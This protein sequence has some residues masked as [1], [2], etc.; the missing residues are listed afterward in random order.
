MEISLAAILLLER[1]R[2]LIANADFGLRHRVNKCD[3][4]RKR[5]LPFNL[6]V[7]LVLQKSLKSVQLHLHEFFE[8]LAAGALWHSPTA[9]AWTQARAKLRHSAFIEL[10]QV[11]V[12]DSVYAGPEPIK[13]WRGRRLLAIDSSTL[14]LPDEQALFDCFG[15]QETSNHLGDCGVRVTQARL[16]VLYDCLNRIGIDTRVGKFSQGEVD[17]AAEHLSAL[18]RDDVVVS[19]RGFAG[20]PYL[21]RI[22]ATGGDFVVR[23]STQSFAAAKALFKRNE[24]GVSVTV[25]LPATPACVAAAKREGLPLTLRVRFVSLRLPTGELEVLATSLLDKEAFPTEAFPEVYD[26]RW[27]IETYYGVLK[28]RLNLENFSGL[29]VEA[30]LQ[31]IHAAVFLSNLE[32]VVTRD[33]AA[34]LPQPGINGRL[35]GAK[36]NRAVSFHAI[37]SRVI[38]LLIGKEPVHEVLAELRELF[39]ANPV[40]V[41]PNRNPPRQPLSFPRSL[42]FQKRVKKAVF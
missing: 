8:K 35:H 5:R 2:A 23:C 9:G 41:R 22:V 40:S 26:H 11:A 12:L 3:F 38:D 39:L 33:A 17:L 1:V 4:T 10:N 14:R 19:D 20:Y 13:T 36:I 15:G 30:I 21:A 31:D 42:H 6:V 37:K 28:G 32:S 16:S 7:L 24:A 29:T 34:Q 27:A 25:T 18:R